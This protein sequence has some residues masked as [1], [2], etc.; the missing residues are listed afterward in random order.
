MENEE[1][2]IDFGVLLNMNSCRISVVH[3]ADWVI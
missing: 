2:K 3:V 1:R